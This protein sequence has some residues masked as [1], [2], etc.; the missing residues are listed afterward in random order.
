ML[1]FSRTQLDRIAPKEKFS[2]RLHTND[3]LMLELP[4][5][6]DTLSVT[7]VSILDNGSVQFMNALIGFHPQA[8]CGDEKSEFGQLFVHR[9]NIERP[10]VNAF[11]YDGNLYAMRISFI[12]YRDLGAGQGHSFDLIIA[13]PTF[14][15]DHVEAERIS[16]GKNLQ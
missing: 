8:I 5:S 1:T 16:L 3:M 4:R 2:T 11:W 7:P 6:H 9:T 14:V 13:P 12:G 10:D 15:I